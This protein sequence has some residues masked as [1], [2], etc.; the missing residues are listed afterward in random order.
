M[1]KKY[2]NALEKLSPSKDEKYQFVCVINLNKIESKISDQQY[3]DLLDIINLISDYQKTYVDFVNRFQ[4]INLKDRKAKDISDL[5][6]KK[7][8]VVVGKRE[9]ET[10]KKHC[11]K[12]MGWI[13][14]Y[15]YEEIL[16]RKFIKEA[17]RKEVNVKNLKSNSKTLKIMS[18]IDNEK[19]KLWVLISLYYRKKYE[20]KVSVFLRGSLDKQASF[21][22]KYIDCFPL[23]EPYEF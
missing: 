10:I 23:F 4:M 8:S 18:K 14:K 16:K 6:R 5:L 3:Y 7:K 22:A 2:I 21:A 11:R 17:I 9:K 12:Y 19:L 15:T 13:F 1:V 20:E